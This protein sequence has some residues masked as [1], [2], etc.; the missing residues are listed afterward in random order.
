MGRRRT[1]KISPRFDWRSAPRRRWATA[2]AA[3]L[4]RLVCGRPEAG[5]RGLLAVLLAA[6]ALPLVLRAADTEQQPLTPAPWTAVVLQD[7]FWNPRLEANRA[8]TIGHNLRELERQGSLGGFALLAGRTADKYHGY[9]WGDSDV[10]KTLEGMTHSLRVHPDAALEKRLEEMVADIAGAQ[11]TDGYLM[12]HLQLAEPRYQHFSEEPTRTCELYSMG[13]LLE[14]AV[15]HHETTGRRE[16]LEVAI[17]LADLIVQEYGPGRIEKPSGHP[18]IEWALTRLYR[19]TNRRAYL[20]LAVALVERARREATR[21]S[22]GRPALGHDEAWGHAV[23]MFYLYRGAT[24]VAMLTG[25]RALLELLQCKWESVT[26]RKLY[27]TGGVGHPQHHEGFAADYVL[28]NRQAYGETCASLANVLWNQQLFLALGDARYVDVLERALYN[29]FLAGVALSGD[30]FFYGNPLASSGGYERSPWFG[31]PCCPTNVVRFLPALG[32][33]QYALGDRAICVNLYAAGTAKLELDGQPVTIAQQTRYPW[34]GRVQ[35]QITPAAEQPFSLRLRIPGW[36]QDAQTPGG[37]YRFVDAAP[38]V[39][40]DLKV[41][42]QPVES[43]FSRGFVSLQRSWKPG[44]TVELE[45][46]MPIRRVYADPRV[47]ADVGRVALQRGPLVY[48][49]EAVDHGGRVG[50]LVL[51]PDAPLAAEHRADLLGGVTVITGQAQ[52]RRDD[53]RMESVALTAVPYYAWNHRGAGEMAV[54]LVEDPAVAGPRQT[55]GWVGSNYTPAYCVNQVQMWHDFRPEVIDRELAAARRYFGIN[56]LRV[57]LHNIPF[58]AER[59]KFLAHLE[60]FLVICQRHGIRPGFTFFDDC[61]RHDGI[62]LDSPTEPVKGYHNGRWAA[63]PQDRERT[64]ENL[65]K[66]QAYV[67]D[68]I[69]AHARD[70]RVLWWEIFNEPGKSEFSIN[71]RRL[72]YAWAKQVA[73]R[74]PVLCCWDD[75]PQTDLVDAHN[76]SADFASWDRQ[77]ELN[78]DKGTV[79]T[80]AGARWLAPRPS[81]GEPCEVMHWLAQRKR[82]GQY[83][84]GVYLCWE[85]MVG[86]SNCRWY[87]GTAEGTPE[88]TVP[89]CGLL[90]PDATPVS[91]AEAEAVRRWATGESRALF[92]DD[93]QDAP[94]PGRPGW[95]A[96]GGRASG[97]R[98]LRLEGDQKMLAGD[99]KWTDYVLEAAVML[100][101]AEGNAGLV[102]RANDPGPGTDQLRGYYVGFDPKTLY[103]GKMENNWQPL[104]T[105]DLAQ[106][107]C[108]VV[109]GVWNQIRVAVQGPRIRVWFNRLHPSADKAA[110]LRI[111]A[112]DAGVPILA[113]AVG[114]R[115]FRVAA[116]FDNVVVL[117]IDTLPRPAQE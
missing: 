89:W 67:Q 47:A 69:R 17:K 106:L 9:L 100:H 74:Q 62:S 15:A 73:P 102:F 101:G 87:W 24:D 64:P 77:L 59:E 57:Y 96:Y 21:W 97:S 51:P 80:E 41:N 58:D 103:L 11:A 113:G 1:V 61:H 86:N 63:C 22:D 36:C 7:T 19:A 16:L 85:L 35:L 33:Y 13:H 30:R 3:G 27:L 40:P 23:A 12:P 14:A 92:F 4:L 34:D 31:C 72:G 75:S 60:Q 37:L 32:Q 81:N 117:P 39:V 94:P 10:Y 48:C 56:T 108:R 2:L 99:A 98:V 79:F 84:P 112:V 6:V 54:W 65:P 42:G 55:A 95:T 78:P 114:V 88:P 82:A 45:L 53:G 71:L 93:F 50:Q 90:W 83:V 107:D 70:E 5:A 49:V 66:F 110:G 109:P 52:A 104:A 76:Y 18:Q 105:Y 29:G 111:D 44:D 38:P 8:V 28:P 115:A 116:S 91:L 68:V 26:H 20:D 25:D 46:P 43:A